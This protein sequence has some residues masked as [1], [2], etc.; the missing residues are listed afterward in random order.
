MGNT[1][2]DTFACGEF[3]DRAYVPAGEALRPMHTVGLLNKNRS[4]WRG[5]AGNRH[6][7]RS[8]PRPAHAAQD[9]TLPPRRQVSAGGWGNETNIF[10]FLNR[11]KELESMKRA[12]ARSL[13][14]W[15]FESSPQQDQLC[16]VETKSFS[17]CAHPRPWDVGAWLAAPATE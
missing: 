2:H 12:G 16:A 1:E 10:I 11:I 13:H 14:A 15:L 9:R 17:L 4:H 7:H 6:I 3:P 5:A 8:P